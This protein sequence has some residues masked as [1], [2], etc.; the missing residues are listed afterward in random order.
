MERL[1]PLDEVFLTIDTPTSRQAIASFCVLDK[2]PEWE[3]VRGHLGVYLAKFPRAAL[4]A[5]LQGHRHVWA[6]CEQLD[7]EYHFP[8]LH[9]TNIHS[10]QDFVAKVSEVFAESFDY[11][12]PLWRFTLVVCE[13]VGL[14]G[15]LFKLHHAFADGVGGL[16]M[17][18][19]WCS[20]TRDVHVEVRKREASRET[21]HETGQVE[22]IASAADEITASGVLRRPAGLLHWL[23][24]FAGLPL[25][26]PLNGRNS[27]KRELQFL[28]FPHAEIRRLKRRFGVSSNDVLL[29]IIASGVGK[30]AERRHAKG[31]G[32][33]LRKLRVVVPVSL[34]KPSA[35]LLLGN[36]LSGVPVAIPLMSSSRSSDA[37]RMI[38]PQEVEDQIRVV[39]SCMRELKNR[40]AFGT[41]AHLANLVAHLPYWLRRISCQH[42]A[43]RTSFICTNMPS[44]VR[45]R[46]FFGAQILENHGVAALMEGHGAAFGL[47][48]YHGTVHLVLVSD[49]E[50]IS[51]AAMLAASV[52]EAFDRI[53]SSTTQEANLEIRHQA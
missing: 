29:G 12:R 22:S 40:G 44:S 52:Q 27:N 20:A 36:H 31:Q 13:P 45:P 34:R 18:D 32:S 6:K 4:R 9:F 41:Y 30:Y 19:W 42:Q 24:G 17:I 35:R 33:E 5:E 25:R 48:T 51:D 16:E 7:L 46:F 3:Q 53:S 37:A 10:R 39:G 28:R 11:S 23:G 38:A 15:V 47:I 49:P 43:R 2:Q 50:I 26:G 21:G 8:K 14:V 1:A